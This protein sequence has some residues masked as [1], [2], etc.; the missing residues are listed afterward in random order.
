MQ[1]HER[2]KGT[3][4]LSQKKWSHFEFYF[5][6]FELSRLRRS[7]IYLQFYWYVLWNSER[8]SFAL[9]FPLYEDNIF[10]R[11]TLYDILC[12]SCLVSFPLLAGLAKITSKT[13][14][15]HVCVWLYFCPEFISGSELVVFFSVHYKYFQ[16]FKELRKRLVS[17]TW[18][19]NVRGVWFTGTESTLHAC[20]RFS[21][22]HLGSGSRWYE[23]PLPETLESWWLQSEGQFDPI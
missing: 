13:T 21:S 23:I 19:D 20:S 14:Y 12:L 7:D 15:F 3:S 1:K 11:M 10:W 8:D 17:E 16:V 6:V 18:S 9:R 4:P 5:G 22:W 2:C